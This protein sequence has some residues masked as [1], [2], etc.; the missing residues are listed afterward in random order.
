MKLFAYPALLV[1]ALFFLSDASAQSASDYYPVSVGR[2]WIYRHTS[3][4]GDSPGKFIREVVGKQLVAGN[5]AVVVK[6]DLAGKEMSYQWFRT[7]PN[8][9]IALISLSTRPDQ[10]TTLV[11][12]DPPLVILPKE[13]R[14]G[15][16][17][18]TKVMMT[19]EANNET[20]L[21]TLNIFRMES[22]CETATVPAGTFTNCL[23]VKMTNLDDDGSESGITYIYYARGIGQVLAE[24]IE[25]EAKRFR[26]EMMEY[27]IK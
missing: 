8:G 15:D 3:P 25:P 20:K 18:E 19:N 1:S 22:D 21:T 12:F 7:L 14:T 11:D 5:E 2:K 6:N 4:E 9:D 26:E 10:G 16:I 24:Q 13:P 23:K 17:W 27:S